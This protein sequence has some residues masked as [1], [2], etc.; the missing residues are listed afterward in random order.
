MTE[1]IKQP[2]RT[3][4]II[5][6][7]ISLFLGMAIIIT[8]TVLWD[9]YSL[10]ALFDIPVSAGRTE[11]PLVTPIAT[12]TPTP[13][14]IA[15]QTPTQDKDVKVTPTPVPTPTPHPGVRDGKFTNGEV[16]VGDLS[17]KS[18]DL[19]VEINKYF[20]DDI[21]YFVAEVYFRDM[22][23]FYAAFANNEYGKRYDKTTN[24]AREHK[25][26]FA[27]SGDYYNARESGIVIRN[28]EIFRQDIE[29]DRATLA[30]Y[31]D[32]TMKNYDPDTIDADTLLAEGAVHTYV[33]GPLL[34]ENGEGVIEFEPVDPTMRHP[35][36][37]IGMVEPYHY[38]F[39]LAD[40]RRPGYSIGMT[41]YEM[42]QKFLDLRCEFAY[43]LD[44]GGSATMVFM[45]ELVNRP[46][47]FT[48]ERGI[49]DA[50]CFIEKKENIDK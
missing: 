18:A 35:R 45:D 4:S 31:N 24:M 5:I 15:T 14:P 1:E 40:G 7:S 3:K 32:G 11:V 20:E 6:W 47:G 43:N 12:H 44:G 34:V 33:F 21:T 39:I 22:D 16:I 49:G 2:K 9:Y 48:K 25:A 23:N 28:S 38:Y 29:P 17:Y 41:L 30:I 46:Q 26:I 13:T 37:A 36:C 10:W 50:I 8:S 27:T 42:S 19:S